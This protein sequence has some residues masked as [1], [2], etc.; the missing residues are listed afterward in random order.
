MWLLRHIK[1]L[2]C[3][4]ASIR[5]TQFCMALNSYKSTCLNWRDGWPVDQDGNT[6][7]LRSTRMPS[8]RTATEFSVIEKTRDSLVRIPSYML[9]SCSVG[10]SDGQRAFLFN[11]HFHFLC[12]CAGLH[13]NDSRS[14]LY[15]LDLTCICYRCH[16]LIRGF[17]GHFMS[18]CN[19][20]DHRR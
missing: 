3:L 9:S 18:R 7:G 17:I 19:E 6:Y 4:N 20:A 8:R 15:A 14:F 10:I 2:I 12:N 11:R 13:G 16:L 1:L 5:R